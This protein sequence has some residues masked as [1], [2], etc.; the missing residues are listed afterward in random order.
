MSSRDVAIWGIFIAA[1]VLVGLVAV[2]Q[3][4]TAHQCQQVR[5]NL[6]RV[7]AILTDVKISVSD[8]REAESWHYETMMD[9]LHYCPEGECVE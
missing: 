6:A 9:C 3:V 1:F 5:Q 2:N 4:S 7:R 8:R